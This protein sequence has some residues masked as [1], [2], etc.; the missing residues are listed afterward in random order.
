MRGGLFVLCLLVLVF[1]WRRSEV[2]MLVVKVRLQKSS[3][4]ETL[5]EKAPTGI[6]APVQEVYG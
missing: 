4:V 1:E 6:Q 3:K 5:S 2:L